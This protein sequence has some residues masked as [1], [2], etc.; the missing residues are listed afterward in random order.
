MWRLKLTFL[1][2]WIRHRPTFWCS[3]FWPI[4]H[5]F[6]IEFLLM[7]KG[8]WGL[9]DN[10]WNSVKSIHIT[11]MEKWNWLI[12]IDALSALSLTSHQLW[13][14]Q[15]ASLMLE[16]VCTGFQDIYPFPLFRF[17]PS[18]AFAIP[19][20]YAFAHQDVSIFF[21]VSDIHPV[22]LLLPTPS[23]LPLHPLSTL[24]C[25]NETPTFWHD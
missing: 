6:V 5:L 18:Q 24:L 20:Q 9:A 2:Q 14:I 17:F 21:W 1:T 23:K 25:K 11:A 22:Y 16:R 10:W 19:G 4:R 7:V 8:G 3:V 12:S 13:Q 15:S